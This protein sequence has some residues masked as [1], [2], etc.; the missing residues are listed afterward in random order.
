MFNKQKYF[1]YFKLISVSLLLLIAAM[2][3]YFIFSK[4]NIE[5]KA[6]S[7]PIITVTPDS[8]NF[9]DVVVGSYA[10]K[11]FTVKN[12]GSGTL[13]GKAETSGPFSCESGC[14]YNLSAGQSQNITIRFSP[15]AAGD[16]NGSV[17]FSGGESSC[18]L[19]N[20]YH[21]ETS[22]SFVKLPEA[23]DFKIDSTNY[24]T[25]VQERGHINFSWLYQGDSSQEQYILAIATNPGFSGAK[26][27]IG[28]QIVPPGL[29]GTSGVDVVPSPDSNEL[30][31]GYNDS[32]YFR[33][34]VKDSEDNWSSDWSNSVNLTTPVHAYPWPDFSWSP[35][36]PAAE[37]TVQIINNSKCFDN[38]N[39]EVNC[40]SWFWTISEATFVDG[41]TATDEEPRIQFFSIGDNSAK[42]RAT[43]VQGFFCPKEKM[44]NVKLPYPGWIEIAPN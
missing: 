31:I 17:D 8:L 33:V 22:Y 21:V 37:E 13:S 1:R 42:L 3:S 34:K 44:I 43:D 9:G 40:S 11:T 4:D 2:S 10:E 20:N 18:I 6:Q 38:N 7:E 24:C 23:I 30:E 32:Y 27:I 29:R 36:D 39:N 14:L 5:I 41:T 28:D 25:G 35:A 16:A 15:T 19:T 26:E 12:S